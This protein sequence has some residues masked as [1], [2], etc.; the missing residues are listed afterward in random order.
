MNI[1]SHFARRYHGSRKAFGASH[2]LDLTGVLPIRE[3]ANY[4]L[5]I[6]ICY[7]RFSGKPKKSWATDFAGMF[8]GDSACS[9]EGGTEGLKSLSVSTTVAGEGSL[10]S[11]TAIL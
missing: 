10:P 8:R 5:I 3:R 2:P 4:L 7:P 6:R 1:P 9:Q 11:E